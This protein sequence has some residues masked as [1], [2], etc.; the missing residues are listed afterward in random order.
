MVESFYV[1]NMVLCDGPTQR[2]FDLYRKVR[3]AMIEQETT[4]L[5]MN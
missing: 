2:G 4:R 1:D 5:M 3:M